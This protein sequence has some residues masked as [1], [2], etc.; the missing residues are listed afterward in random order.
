MPISVA[1]PDPSNMRVGKQAYVVL[2]HGTDLHRIHPSIYAPDQFND[3]DK[4]DARFSPL[5]EI[6]GA[7]VPTIYGAETFDCAVCEIILRCP[8]VPTVDPRTGVPTFQIVFPSDFI[9]YSHSIV[10]T[11]ADLKLLD[12]TIA[13]QRKIG[14][15]HNALLAGPRSTY[16]ETRAWAGRIH[17][18]C[19]DVAGLYY[20]SY[21]LG[22]SFAVVLFGDRVPP[23]ALAAGPTRLVRDAPCHD[24][25]SALAKSLWIEYRD[26]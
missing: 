2:R 4:G 20:S 9:Q 19:P 23:G 12:L 21:Q 14:I 15:N 16:P 1:I 24:D 5:R 13:G 17:A 18:N 25:I 10:R 26:V 3:T 22:P 6:G 8:D 11:T 7:I